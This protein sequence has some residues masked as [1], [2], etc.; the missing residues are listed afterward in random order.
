MLVLRH[1]DQRMGVQMGM[2]MMR[3]DMGMHSVWMSQMGGMGVCVPRTTLKN[4]G[5]RLIAANLDDQG[6]L[7]ARKSGSSCSR[8]D[9]L[10]AL[11]WPIG[12]DKWPRF[13]C[14]WFTVDDRQEQ[15]KYQKRLD[16]E[17]S[18][19]LNKSNNYFTSKSN[20]KHWKKFK[21]F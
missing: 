6:S 5:H 20:K 14:R 4:Q 11:R 19:A 1:M 21:T 8:T 15:G 3:Q 18:K 17:E 7:F 10:G 13:G 16:V 9:L 2:R 12:E